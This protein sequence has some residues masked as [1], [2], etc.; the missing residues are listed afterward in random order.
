MCKE[1]RKAA[2]KATALLFLP[3]ALD[4]NLIYIFKRSCVL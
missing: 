4:G 3:N 1:S 2:A